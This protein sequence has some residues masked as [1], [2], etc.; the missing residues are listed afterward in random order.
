MIYKIAFGN[1]NMLL[2]KNKCSLIVLK[3]LIEPAG[4]LHSFP[5]TFINLEYGSPWNWTS[6]YHPFDKWPG[7]NLV[8]SSYM[9]SSL[10]NCC[11][12]FE[13][14]QLMSFKTIHTLTYTNTKSHC[15]QWSGKYAGKPA[16]WC[17]GKFK[18]KKK[19]QQWSQQ[20]LFKF[21]LLRFW[22]K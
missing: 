13:L 4:L 2:M 11:Q 19:W 12:R 8:N 16:M 1:Y 6:L 15:Y 14:L 22:N 20:F 21:Y 3:L 17:P 9:S 10:R 18:K 5:S 7:R